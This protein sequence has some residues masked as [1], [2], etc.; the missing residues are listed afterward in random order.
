[1]V[2]AFIMNDG[3]DDSVYKSEFRNGAW[4]HPTALSD[5]ISPSGNGVFEHARVS[6][7]SEGNTIIVWAQNDDTA[8]TRV[9]LKSEYRA[10]V[11]THPISNA[12]SMFT[13][14]IGY[15]IYPRVAFNDDGAGI[16]T[17]LAYD[18]QAVV[19]VFKSEYR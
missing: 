18:D 19:Q 6:M 14:S 16:I 7:D 3:T 12:I 13:G 1:M 4:S 9:L 8:L 17:W 15:S 5:K 11:W 2:V 10:G